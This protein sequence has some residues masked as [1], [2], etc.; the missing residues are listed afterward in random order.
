MVVAFDSSDHLFRTNHVHATRQVANDINAQIF[1]SIFLVVVAQRHSARLPAATITP[2]RKNICCSRSFGRPVEDLEELRQ[3]VATHA[4]RA[5][6]KLR[7]QGLAASVIQ[8]FLCTNRHKPDEPQ[9]YPQGGRELLVPTSFTPE[10]VGEAAAVLRRIYRPGHR[11]AKAGV[12]CLGLVPD[13][14]KQTSLFKANNP[15]QTDKERRLMAAVD[16]LNLHFGRGTV[17]PAT[18]GFKPGWAMRQAW[19]SPCYTTRLADV[20]HARLG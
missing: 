11:Y 12:L 20:P 18:A 13:E 3:A 1:I 4:A 19:K 15:A 16:A 5:G 14:E 8:V 17:R 6:E 7:R 9:A 2:P 10:L